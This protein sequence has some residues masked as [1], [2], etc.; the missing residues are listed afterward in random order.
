[1]LCD[2]VAG[3]LSDRPAV[4]SAVTGAR[5]PCARLVRC[6][7]RPFPDFR[8]TP[9]MEDRQHYDLP[10]CDGVEHGVRKVAHSNAPNFIMLD[11]VSVGVLGSK[12]D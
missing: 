9:R 3:G 2:A 8:V 1:M 5:R 11:G 7:G 6:Y 10:T 12:I 4:T